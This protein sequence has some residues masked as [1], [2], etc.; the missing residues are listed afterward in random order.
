M[1]KLDRSTK[2]EILQIFKKIVDDPYRYKPLRYKL[3]GLYRARI[4]KYRVIFEINGN[5]VF[6][7][8]IEHRRKVYRH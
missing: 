3:K 6:I 1:K 5:I 8:S 4:G 2:K 7:M